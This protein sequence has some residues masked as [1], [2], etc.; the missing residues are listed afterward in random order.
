MNYDSNSSLNLDRILEPQPNNV[1]LEVP[2]LFATSDT[3]IVKRGLLKTKFIHVLFIRSN[4]EK[5]GIEIL[6]ADTVDEKCEFQDWEKCVKEAEDIN[7]RK[8]N[9]LNSARR[10]ISENQ[11][12]DSLKRKSSDDSSH[13]DTGN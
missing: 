2:M 10:Q 4:I 7:R 5:V 1:L 3:S 9:R 13:S 8:V 12:Y 11:C 6:F